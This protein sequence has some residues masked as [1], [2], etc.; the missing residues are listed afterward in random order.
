M[1]LYE[2]PVNSAADV[3]G[4]IDEMRGYFQGGE[5]L[6]VDFRIRQLNRLG[7]YLRAHEQD[8]LD[9]LH[10]D[11]GK[12]AFESYATELG[13]VYDEIRTCIKH[14]R[15]WARPRHVRTPLMNFP[16]TSGLPVPVWRGGRAL[17]V[18]LPHP[19]RTCA[20]RRRHRRR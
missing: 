10:A 7:A 2:K 1:N 13:L 9:A 11:L 19:A 15:C 8:V 14:V 16:A 3:Q 17:A 6:S 18:E 12:S 20:A 4:I 5:T